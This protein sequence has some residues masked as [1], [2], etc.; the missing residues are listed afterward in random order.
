MTR[1]QILTSQGNYDAAYKV[2]A[3]LSAAE[4]D[5]AMLQNQIAW[6]IAT[7][8]DL[9]KRDLALAEK[10][11]ERGNKAAKGKDPNI[12]D[13]LV[14]VQFMNGKKRQAIETEQKAVDLAEG[15]QK[16]EFKEFLES[17][18][19]DKLPEVDE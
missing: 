12:L 16:E 1:F 18:K 9:E 3:D 2:V 8:K 4:P 15:D 17:Y 14:R 13:R 10:I 6:T 5:N 7:R 11:A 19:A